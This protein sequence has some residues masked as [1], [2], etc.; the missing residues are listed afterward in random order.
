MARPVNL[1]ARAR[2]L[3]AAEICFA[4]NGFSGTSIRDVGR[5]LQIGNSSLLHH[6]PTK[7]RLYAAVLERVAVTLDALSEVA[8]H[9]DAAEQL[10]SLHDAVFDWHRDHPL[11][12]RL[13]V[14]EL[15]DNAGRAEAAGRWYFEGPIRKAA[16]VLERGQRDGVYRDGDPLLQLF[17]L[18]GA[19]GYFFAGLPT[20]AGIFGDEQTVLVTRF[21]A[22]SWR[23]FRAA[24]LVE[25][26]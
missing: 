25:A 10:R 12:A 9:P 20:L 5:V 21:R 7:R 23:Q 14:R 26:P 3:D 17:Q 6:F 13:V 11:Y 1:E 15:S 8:D 24:L 4:E 2:I 19:V 16:A 18:I 22:E